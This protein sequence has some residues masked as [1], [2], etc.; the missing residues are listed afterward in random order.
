MTKKE[1]MKLL[2]EWY[3]QFTIIDSAWTS[4]EKSFRGLD[5]ESMIGMALWGTFGEYSKLV[6][7]LVGDESEWLSWYCWDND[8]GEKGFKAGKK[9]RLRS[10]KTIEDL[11]WLI[12]SGKKG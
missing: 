5:A 9:G 3:T 7:L 12:S 1:K 11:C 10:I 6:S 4:L 8:M 2:N